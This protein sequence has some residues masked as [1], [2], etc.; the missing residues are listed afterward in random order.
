MYEGNQQSPDKLEI[1]TLK[2]KI[3]KLITTFCEEK[4]WVS[5]S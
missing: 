4:I 1:W 5:S 3:L 2:I